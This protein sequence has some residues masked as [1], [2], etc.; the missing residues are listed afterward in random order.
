MRA[1]QQTRP[2]RTR[3]SWTASA[4][5]EPPAKDARPANG[6]VIHSAS[7][8]VCLSREVHVVANARAQSCAWVHQPPASRNASADSRAKFA[9]T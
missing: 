9:E 7:A 1:R 3:P 2:P 5:K 8:Y 4:A 6:R